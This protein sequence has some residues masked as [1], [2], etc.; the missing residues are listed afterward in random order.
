MET[1]AIT[2]S[3]SEVAQLRRAA[4]T[5]HRR[6]LAVQLGANAEVVASRLAEVAETVRDLLDRSEERGKVH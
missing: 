6:A 2:L 5:L 4:L 3:A 1:K